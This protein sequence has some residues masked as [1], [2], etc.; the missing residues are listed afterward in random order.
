MIGTA[1]ILCTH[2][3]P[4]YQLFFRNL[5]SVASK[6]ENEILFCTLQPHLNKYYG[7]QL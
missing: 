1:M 3:I 2:P 5:A 4:Y 7:R 6:K